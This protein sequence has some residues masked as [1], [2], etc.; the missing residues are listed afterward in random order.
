M[1]YSTEMNNYLDTYTIIYDL[2]YNN[3]FY[4]FVYGLK[5][6]IPQVP[7][8]NDNLFTYLLPTNISNKIYL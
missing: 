5:Y 1:Y 6:F 7:S 8:G 3:S 4:H 2:S